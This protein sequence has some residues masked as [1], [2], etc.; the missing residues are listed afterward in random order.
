MFLFHPLH[1]CGF[2]FGVGICQYFYD[3]KS[4]MVK[5]EMNTIL[6]KNELL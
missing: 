2:C 3:Q 5:E 1:T 6:E 4:S